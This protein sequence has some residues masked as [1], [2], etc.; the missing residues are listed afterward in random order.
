MAAVNEPVKIVG[1]DELSAK[2]GLLLLLASDQQMLESLMLGGLVIEREIKIH[3][4]QQRLILTGQLRNSIRAEAFTIGGK[5]AVIIG[6]NI[7]YAAIHEFGGQAGRNKAT[8]IPARPYMRPAWDAK[9][10]EA[11][12]V[13]EEQLRNKV[14]GV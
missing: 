9:K 2:I 14:L 5:P 4:R 6:T 1:I 13:V 7:V 10:D 3:I 8:K 11:L 12:D